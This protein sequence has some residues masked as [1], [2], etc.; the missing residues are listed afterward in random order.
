M[1]YV[2]LDLEWNGTFHK[3]WKTF[4]NEII[5]F[6]AVKAD[7]EMHL[8]DTFS[9]VVQPQV[10][11]KLSGKVKKLTNITEEE[12]E[13][14]IPFPLALKRFKEFL[15]DAVLM[16]WGTSDILT[17]ME[18]CR[19]YMDQSQI[20]FLKKYVDLQVYCQD[21]LHYDTCLLYTSR[22]GPRPL[23][24]GIRDGNGT[25][26]LECSGISSHRGRGG[27]DL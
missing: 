2:I 11:K 5:E 14:G 27:P 7:D 22:H 4:F 10:G 24:P 8:L 15:Q 1:K 13:Q 20:P 12:L 3:K 21:R 18:N 19:C 17:L 16:T 9:C 23:P 6:G 25:V 26:R